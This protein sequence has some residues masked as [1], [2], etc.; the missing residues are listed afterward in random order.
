MTVEKTFYPSPTL[1]Q[2]SD[3]AFA[4]TKVL[5]VAREGVNFDILVSNDDVPGL[6]TRQVLHQP[7]YGVIVFSGGLPF[8]ENESVNVVYETNP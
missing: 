3:A 5:M 2:I 8:N 4:Y 6:D 7:A 1:N